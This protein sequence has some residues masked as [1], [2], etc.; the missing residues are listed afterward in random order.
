MAD[1]SIIGSIFLF[2]FFAGYA[3]RSLVSYNRRINRLLGSR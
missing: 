3:V 2:S 1:I